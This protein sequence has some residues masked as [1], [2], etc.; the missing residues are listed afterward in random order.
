LQIDVA[1]CSSGGGG[2]RWALCGLCLVTKDLLGQKK[3]LQGRRPSGDVGRGWRNLTAGEVDTEQGQG[4]T[5]FNVLSIG[6]WLVS[7]PY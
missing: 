5:G 7:D 1:I 6:Q 3:K 2:I 4:G